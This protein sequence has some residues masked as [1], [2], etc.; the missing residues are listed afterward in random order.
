[1]TG[2]F[3]EQTT[4]WVRRRGVKYPYADDSTYSLAGPFDIFGLPHAILVAP[5]GEVVFSGPSDE[6][7]EDMIKARLPGAL[8]KP[9]CELPDTVAPVRDAL[10]KGDFTAAETAWSKLAADVEG[11]ADAEAAMKGLF[12]LRLKGLEAAVKAGDLFGASEAAA[13]L[14][15]HVATKPEAKAR[16]DAATAAIKAAPNAE[17]RLAA[18]RRLRELTTPPASEE[19]GKKALEEAQR[20]LKDQSGTPLAAPAERAVRFLKRISG[21]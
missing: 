19:D 7:T 17:P 10:V 1:M 18:Q 20:I 4:E 6:I 5:T 15:P 16:V 3:K 2:G 13:A 12:E 21:R 8:K 11:R 14:L 9:L